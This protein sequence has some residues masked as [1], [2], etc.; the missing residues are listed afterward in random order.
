VRGFFGKNWAHRANDQS[1]RNLFSGDLGVHYGG[2][3]R[4]AVAVVGMAAVPERA[5]NAP[6]SE[7]MRPLFLR[8]L[9]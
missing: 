6:Q 5:E 4:V 3:H 8:I 2:K 9:A 1:K 7:T